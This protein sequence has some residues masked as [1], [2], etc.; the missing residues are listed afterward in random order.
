ARQPLPAAEHEVFPIDF[1]A[2]TCGEH[3]SSVELL[4]LVEH[5]C[6]KGE[7]CP[8]LDLHF[9]NPE[10][11]PLWLLLDVSGEFAVYL[12]EVDILHD[13]NAPGP[14]AWQFLGQNLHEALR[15]P[16]GADVTVR[17]LRYFPQLADLRVVFVDHI[18]LNY[19]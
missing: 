10:S 9:R 13:R 12:E 18:A 4:K 5:P 8:I 7:E 3:G 15:L 14:P 19:N 17:N 11:R 1:E 16:S 6:G 2:P